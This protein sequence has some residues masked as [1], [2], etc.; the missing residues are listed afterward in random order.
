MKTIF[1]ALLVVGTTSL[2]ILAN[3]KPAYDEYDRMMW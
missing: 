1:L 2:L 3:K